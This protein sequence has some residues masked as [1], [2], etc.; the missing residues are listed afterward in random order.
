M[1]CAPPPRS[2]HYD[3]RA[4]YHCPCGKRLNHRGACW[5]DRQ[6]CVRLRDRVISGA[7]VTGY[8]LAILPLWETG[9]AL[10]RLH[11]AIDARLPGVLPPMPRSLQ[12]EPDP[13]YDPGWLC[14]SR[15]Q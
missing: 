14:E 4:W 10:H 3:P 5:V 1:T 7:I 12:W 2:T 6:R 8:A 9:N 11:A 13:E 15:R